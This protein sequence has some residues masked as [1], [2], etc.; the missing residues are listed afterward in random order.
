VLTNG[1]RLPNRPRQ[2][3]GS[4]RAGAPAGRAPDDGKAQRRLS[5]TLLAPFQGGGLSSEVDRM[6]TLRSHTALL[7]AACSLAPGCLYYGNTSHDVD[8][9]PMVDTG[10]G[11][12]ILMPGESAPAFPGGASQSG[13]A[14]GSDSSRTTGTPPGEGRLSMIGGSRIDEVSHTSTK[15]EPIWLKYLTLPFAVVAAPF[16]AAAEAVKGEPEPGPEV[17]RVDPPRPQPAPQAGSYDER[18]IDGLERE[19]DARAGAAGPARAPSPRAPSIADELAA[20]QRSPGGAPESNAPRAPEPVSPPPSPDAPPAPRPAPSAEPAADGIVDRNEDGRIDLWLYREDG[21]IVR[22]VL[23][24]DFDGRPDTTVH[25]DRATQRPARVEEDAN[26]DGRSDAWTEYQNGVI[27]RRRS[28]ANHDGTV[29]TW[30]FYQAGVIARHEQDTTGSGFRD[31]VGHYEGGKLVREEQ[32]TS[33][34]GRA[35][36][37]LHYDAQERVLRREE[38]TDHDG[39]VDVISHYEKGRLARRELLDDTAQAPAPQAPVATP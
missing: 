27:A 17:P 6:R 2:A 19:L 34:D 30:T 12:T 29:D 1:S 16:V 10:V 26:G 7:L 24:E 18:V 13:A 14:G 31:R 20:L 39:R 4:S 36:V 8:R 15:E 23:D 32:D 3:G 38:D 28:D 22:R 5:R 37:V 33:G 35:D 25:Y 9:T 21:E 11:A